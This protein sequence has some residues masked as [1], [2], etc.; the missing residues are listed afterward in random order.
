MQETTAPPASLSVRKM[1]IGTLVAALALFV[2]V[3]CT[4]AEMAPVPPVGEPPVLPLVELEP[5][6]GP[7][8]TPVEVRGN[9]FPPNSMVEMYLT[10][11]AEEQCSEVF[12]QGVA[13]QNGHLVLGF[14]VPAQCEDGTPVSPGPLSVTLVSDFEEAAHEEVFQVE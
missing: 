7:V 4:E 5:R 12:D 14:T 11:Y 6:L 3:G 1:I 13:D 8:G 9:G 2:L 10:P